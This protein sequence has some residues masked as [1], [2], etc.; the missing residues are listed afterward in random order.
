MDIINNRRNKSTV[1]ILPLLYPD[2]KFTDV[3]FEHFISCY[4]SD[5][6]MPNPEDSL[7]IEFDDNVARFRF[8]EDKLEDYKKI[9]RSQYSEISDESKR[10]ILYF[11]QVDDSSYLYSVLYKTQK[12]LDYWTVKTGKEILP[13]KEK[14]YWP[15]FNTYEETRGLN[16][17]YRMFSFKLIK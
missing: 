8:P 13:S 12:I 2:I 16:T 3:L 4:I 9:M 15:K 5:V 10:N 7:I 14:E 6:T 1:F 17:L 11:W